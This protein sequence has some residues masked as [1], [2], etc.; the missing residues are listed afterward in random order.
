MFAAD[1]PHAEP[2][3]VLVEAPYN[4]LNCSNSQGLGDCDDAL[5]SG[6]DPGCGWKDCTE[7]TSYAVPLALTE[8]RYRAEVV[9]GGIDIYRGSC[10][11]GTP[12][13]LCTTFSVAIPSLGLI[14]QGGDASCSYVYNIPLIFYAG[15]E[16]VYFYF[17]DSDNNNNSGR[18]RIQVTRLETDPDKDRDGDGQES[19][20]FGGPDCND[21]NVLIYQGAEEKTNQLDDDCDGQVDEHLGIP[22]TPTPSGTS[23]TPEGEAGGCGCVQAAATGPAATSPAG[24][25]TS[26]SLWLGL[27]GWWRRRRM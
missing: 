3:I 19:V 4:V 25:V 26:A 15:T 17:C 5:L 14:Q 23:P 2:A 24:I 16:S 21:D 11:G 6:T 20:S 8:G 9:G 27:L 12:S 18:L 7:L 13:T 10:S 22:T 1:M